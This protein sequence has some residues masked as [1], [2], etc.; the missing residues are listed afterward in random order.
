M[1]KRYTPSWPEVVLYLGLGVLL[2]GA[3][4]FAPEPY[5]KPIAGLIAAASMFIGKAYR[6]KAAAPERITRVPG[7]RDGFAAPEILVI[8]V[9]VAVLAFV[10]ATISG[11]NGQ[12]PSASTVYRGACS[13]AR[14]ACRVVNAVCPETSG[15]EQ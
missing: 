6:E 11:C 12:S 13:A 15:G 1:L 9:I 5:Q 8:V 7:R 3:F 2:V 10:S 14:S 4:I